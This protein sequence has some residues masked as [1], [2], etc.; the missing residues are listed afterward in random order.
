VVTVPTVMYPNYGKTE[1]L[2]V[3]KTA[4]LDKVLLDLISQ[5]QREKFLDYHMFSCIL[6]TCHCR[7]R[8]MGNS[9]ICLDLHPKLPIKILV[10]VWSKCKL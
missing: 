8:N 4:D 5:H 3:K 10:P 9:K 2:Y 7:T 6:S 1:D